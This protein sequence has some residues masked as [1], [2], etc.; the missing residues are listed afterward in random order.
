MFVLPTVQVWARERI[1]EGWTYG[2]VRDNDRKKHP[3][4]RPYFDLPEGSKQYDRDST[5]ETLKVP[6][7]CSPFV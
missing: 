4:L 2:A 5:R 1:R 6:A 3:D 7:A